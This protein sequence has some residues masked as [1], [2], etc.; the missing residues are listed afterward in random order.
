MESDPLFVFAREVRE[1]L[2][3]DPG[4]DYWRKQRELRARAEAARPKE[5]LPK[6]SEP[7]KFLVD[8]IRYIKQKYQG[9]EKTISSYLL[10]RKYCHIYLKDD[11]LYYVINESSI[12]EKEEKNKIN[13]NLNMF[14]AALADDLDAVNYALKGFIRREVGGK[15]ASSTYK[16][17]GDKVS[18]LINKKKLHRSVYVKGN[19]KAKYCKI[20]NEF[21]LLNKLKNKIIE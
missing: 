18:L 6:E 4:E 1:G 2:R 19:G 13:L 15:K 12:A 3:P 5:K 10:D 7:L 20:N 8:S 14:P 16:L 17:N 11:E 21:V 9:Q